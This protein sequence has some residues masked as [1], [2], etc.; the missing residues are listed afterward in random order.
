MAKNVKQF[1]DRM[2]ALR[3]RMSKVDPRDVFF[4]EKQKLLRETALAIDVN[5]DAPH[6]YCDKWLLKRRYDKN[7]KELIEKSFE[8]T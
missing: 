7:I 5:R 3:D 4:L 8:S 6:K 2:Q 1:L